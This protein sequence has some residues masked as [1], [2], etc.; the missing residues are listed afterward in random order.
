MEQSSPSGLGCAYRH[1]GL[2]VKFG[3]YVQFP[4]YNLPANAS[5]NRYL[6]DHPYLFEASQYQLL[7]FDARQ[8]QRA[9]TGPVSCKNPN[10]TQ[11]LNGSSDPTRTLPRGAS[12]RYY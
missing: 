2:Q 9:L 3:T 5:L 1:E 10:C 11:V 8:Y 6:I 7:I 4:C 12:F